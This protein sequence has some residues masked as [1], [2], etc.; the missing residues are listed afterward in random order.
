MSFK[1]GCS[2]TRLICTTQG[3]KTFTLDIRTVSKFPHTRKR[4]LHER[5]EMAS[6][7]AVTD[8]APD[9]AITAG[10]IKGDDAPQKPRNACKL[11]SLGYFNRYLRYVSSHRAHRQVKST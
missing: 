10:E 1:W 8:N 9:E 5:P 6:K 2:S 11:S 7:D 3:V 4:P